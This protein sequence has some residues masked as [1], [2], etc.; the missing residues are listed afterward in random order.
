MRTSSPG[1][2]RAPRLPRGARL[3][4][5]HGVALAAATG[6]LVAAVAVLTALGGLTELAATDGIRHRLAADQA[7]GVEVDAQQGAGDTAADPLVRAALDRAL[8]GVPHRTETALRAAGSLAAPLPGQPTGS[9]DT[10]TAGVPASAPL[11]P[12][13]VPDPGRYARLLDG[14]WPDAAPGGGPPAVALPERAATLLHARV[15]TVLDVPAPLGPGRLDLTVTGIFRPD[16]AAAAYWHGIGAPGRTVDD[17]LL[18]DRRQLLADRGLAGNARA[19]WLALPDVSGL[20]L[21]QLTALRTRTTAFAGGDP[22]RSVYRGAPPAL[23]DTAVHTGLP[24]LLDSLARPALAARAGLAVPT[25]LLAVLAAVVLVLT[26]RRMAVQRR[27]E[28]LLRLSRGVG[29]ARLL[30]QSAGEWAVTALPAALLGVLAAGPLLRG[31]L[32]L[33]GRPTAALPG[34]W[35]TALL[36]VAFAL[37]VHGAAALLP[38]ARL[39][40][41]PDPNGARARNPRRLAAQ[42]AG[43]DLALLALAVLG[44]LQ[45]RHYGSLVPDDTAGSFAD[46]VDPVLVLVPVVMALAGAVLLLRLLPALAR[47]LERGARRGTGLVLPMSGW[48]V[49][50]DP[51]GQLVP[52]LVTLLALA[53]ASLAAGTLA[54]L[55]VSDRDRAV[56]AVGGDLRVDGTDPERPAERQGGPLAALPGVTAVSGVA[57]QSA[58]VG[59]TVVRTV[60]FAAAAD[61]GRLPAVRPDL[62]RGAAADLLRSLG[63]GLPEQGLALPG[64][65]DAL[66][67]TARLGAEHPLLAPVELSLSV[68]TADGL[69]DVL[70]APLQPDGASHMLRLTLAGLPPTAYPLRLARLGL[71]FEPPKPT[72]PVLPR[73]TLD[74]RVTGLSAVGGGAGPAA[75]TLPTGVRW[76]NSAVAAADPVTLGC[77]GAGDLPGNDQWLPAELQ[78]PGACTVDGGGDALLH[79]VVR[80]QADVGPLGERSV[81]FQASPAAQPAA[82][83]GA[84]LPALADAA[85]LTGLHAK[86]GDTLRLL[87]DRSGPD[88]TA[89]RVRI[90]GRLDALP[91]Y[92][93]GAG[94]LVLDLRQL[95]VDR[96]VSGGPEV[97]PAGWWLASADPDATAAAL[98]AHPELGTGRSARELARQY[99]ADPFRAG[100]R[101]AWLLALV[102]APLFAL[103]AVTLHAV[104]EARSRQREFAVLRALGARRRQLAALLRVE[105]VALAAVP[106][107]LGGALGVLLAGLL[108]PLL[109]VD[110]NSWPVFPAL[111]TAPGRPAAVLVALAAGA[112]LCVAVVVL[113]R[114]LARVDLARALRAGEQ[115]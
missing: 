102:V 28:H 77:P 84:P 47:L 39:A 60:A 14:S 41:D 36:P 29:G 65:P 66:E 79:A 37:L 35:R 57:E 72:D 59:S 27:A 32:R 26:A 49:G 44:Y 53:T 68:R 103:T 7:L 61:P 112:V 18:M 64:R 81:L 105:Q 23:T 40:L 43:L 80:T 55:P 67:V 109:V 82:S 38:V 6:A 101:T 95:A 17:L 54:A 10:G 34:G 92:D 45:L 58:Y 33:A 22:A 93:R 42:R 11:F 76:W 99:A 15:G 16:A 71:R 70:T 113:A 52:V 96:A 5:R 50:R 63:A 100:Q 20:T 30:A 73:Q 62:A 12:L 98:A 106:A 87:W 25:A 24:D 1:N 3:F 51:A 21:D 8:A 107:V 69:T 94:H 19:A 110:D 75:V 97:S 46:P 74:L 9:G 83:S 86:V 111:R 90:V 104:A 89:T 114:L 88:A 2:E 13:A 108:L 115:G 56:F 4:G 91:G 48:R 31:A 85:L 78:A